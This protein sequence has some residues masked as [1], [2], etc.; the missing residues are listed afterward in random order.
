[1]HEFYENVAIF[2]PLS[3]RSRSMRYLVSAD[4]FKGTLT[5]F[6]SCDVIARSIRQLDRNAQVDCLPIADG[7]EG[8]SEI[9]GLQLGANRLSLPTLDPLHRKV[10]VDCFVNGHEAYLDMSSASGLW[11]ISP[12]ERAPLRSTTFGTGLMIRQLADRG[13]K[14]LFLGLGGSATVDA[15]IGMAAAIGYQFFDDRDDIVTPVPEEFV[16]VRRVEAPVSISIPHVIGLVDVDTPLLGP[17]G[18]VCTFGPQK[19]LSLQQVDQLDREL[20]L[21]VQRLRGQDAPRH[22]TTP[23]SGAAGG[24]GYGVLRFLGGKL[25][26]GFSIVAD[27][28]DIRSKIARA[29]VVI[30]GEG[31]LDSQSL[32]GKG[33]F[34]VAQ[35]ARELDRPVWAVAGIIEDSECVTDHFDRV[36]SLVSGEVSLQQALTH[37]RA[38]LSSATKRLMGQSA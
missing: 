7:G 24:F 38:A 31:K 8:T 18:A 23:G 36:A 4:K 30:T 11:R 33:P 22:W 28:L 16:R 17:G 13:I 35:L 20:S 6:E 26:S 27:R 19:G 32:R 10:S 15:G 5:A 9:I 25:V 29:D 3:Y 21:L 12:D 37:P 2:H 34:A 14:Q 1:L